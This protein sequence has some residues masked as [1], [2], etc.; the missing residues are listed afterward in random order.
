[1]KFHISKCGTWWYICLSLIFITWLKLIEDNRW[2]KFLNHTMLSILLV[3]HNK[4]YS[5]KRLRFYLICQIRIKRP[6]M[7][8]FRFS[9]YI[10]FFWHKCFNF[11]DSRNII[12]SL[13]LSLPPTHTHTH[14]YNM[15]W[16]SC[17]WS[18]RSP[19]FFLLINQLPVLQQQNQR[20]LGNNFWSMWQIHPN[21]S[22][23]NRGVWD[24]VTSGA[25]SPGLQETPRLLKRVKNNKYKNNFISNSN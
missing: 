13:P 9:T 3:H 15:N 18:N 1:M 21:S 22:D 23:P 8:I 6:D 5:I 7:H 16:V 20:L 10:T 12:V 25:S 11:V 2:H 4:K 24:G 17:Q 19:Y 14:T